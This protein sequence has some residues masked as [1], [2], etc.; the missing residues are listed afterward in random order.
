MNSLDCFSHN[1]DMLQEEN[2]SSLRRLDDLGNQ[3]KDLTDRLQ[4]EQYE[5]VNN[6]SAGNEV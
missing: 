2:D 5:G 1:R 3:L 4:E 6:Q